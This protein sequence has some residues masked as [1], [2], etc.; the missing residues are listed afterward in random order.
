MAKFWIDGT[1]LQVARDKLG[2]AN[3]QPG[4]IYAEDMPNGAW[5]LGYTTIS[6]YEQPNAEVT[7][8]TLAKIFA[9]MREAAIEWD[10][11]FPPTDPSDS[12]VA[13]IRAILAR[14]VA[15][16]GDRLAASRLEL[17]N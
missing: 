8:R 14:I 15:Q 13:Q 12:M 1:L 11:K 2:V 6:R 16:A 9:A 17:G 7:D 4:R 3:R 10:K 5:G